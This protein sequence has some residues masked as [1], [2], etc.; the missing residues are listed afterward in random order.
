MGMPLNRGKSRPH[1]LVTQP[2]SR[3]DSEESRLFFSNAFGRF[4]IPREAKN[5]C[6]VAAGS[7]SPLANYL[8]MHTRM[9][10]FWEVRRWLA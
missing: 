10:G 5:L 9:N 2:P 1:S 8:M 3:W 4:V 6:G 7:R